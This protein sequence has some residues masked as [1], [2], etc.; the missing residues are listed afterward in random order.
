[1][2]TA[3]LA[4]ILVSAGWIAASILL[5]RRT[6]V[7]LLLAIALFAV[8]IYIV[9]PAREAPRGAGPPG[10]TKWDGQYILSRRPTL[11]TLDTNFLYSGPMSTQSWEAARATTTV[12]FDG[13]EIWNSLEFKQFYEPKTVEIT[14]GRWFHF[15]VLKSANI[16]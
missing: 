12:A 1:M 15:F 2:I 4:A 10:H 3:I 5:P 9:N 8:H 16:P 13:A 14:P 6:V 11:L 7:F